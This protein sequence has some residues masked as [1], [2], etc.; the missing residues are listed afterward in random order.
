MFTKNRTISS[1]L[2]GFGS[3][4]Q[5]NVPDPSLRTRPS[6]P[7][8]SAKDGKF[9]YDETPYRASNTSLLNMSNPFEKIYGK[10]KSESPVPPMALEQ[11]E[12]L[13]QGQLSENL[14]DRSV[15]IA[16]PKKGNAEIISE[17]SLRERV[18]RFG[19]VINVST[20]S[21]FVALFYPTLAQNLAVWDQLTSF[22]LRIAANMKSSV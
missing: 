9:A 1:M 3:K 18:G 21:I 16:F 12:I 6:T 19:E 15:K 2:A 11:T 20:C 4:Q 8:T 13:P 17:A 22:L 10:S 7:G 14:L 5:Q